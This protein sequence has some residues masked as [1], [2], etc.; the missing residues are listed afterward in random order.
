MGDWGVGSALAVAPPRGLFCWER[1]VC[2]TMM[3]CEGHYIFGE[4]S[5]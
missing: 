4:S 1:A 2:G 3:W 5:V